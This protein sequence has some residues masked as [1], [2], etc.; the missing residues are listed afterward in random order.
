MLLKLQY[1]DRLQVVLSQIE[2][3]CNG[4]RTRDGFNNISQLLEEEHLL[5]SLPLAF[6]LLLVHSNFLDLILFLTLNFVYT[7]SQ[8]LQVPLDQVFVLDRLHIW[9]FKDLVFSKACDCPAFKAVGVIVLSQLEHNLMIVNNTWIFEYLFLFPQFFHLVIQF[10]QRL[11]LDSFLVFEAIKRSRNEIIEDC[12]WLVYHVFEELVLQ[13]DLVKLHVRNLLD[14]IE[15]KWS[16]FVLIVLRQ[17]QFQYNEEA[18][19]AIAIEFQSLIIVISVRI[20]SS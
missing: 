13:I 10:V 9:F 12:L 17:E 15:V 5:M 3:T 4:C 20:G 14:A 7:R 19:D 18:D 16:F 2:S 6:V 1:T 8:F 11:M